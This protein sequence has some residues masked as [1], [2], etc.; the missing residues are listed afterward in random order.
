M[1]AY[2]DPGDEVIIPTPSFSMFK[3]YAQLVGGIPVQ[4]PYRQPDLG[5]PVSELLAAIGKR[6]RAICIASPNNPTGGVLGPKSKRNRFSE[7]QMA[8]LYSSTKPTL[9]FTARRWLG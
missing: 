6:T 4:V 3:F 2:V 8:A 9:T 5:F 1:H 7:P